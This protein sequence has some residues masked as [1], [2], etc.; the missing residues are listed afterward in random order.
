ML[1]TMTEK[2][3]LN[4][5]IIDQSECQNCGSK[6]IITDKTRGEMICSQCGLV[7]EDK[8]VDFSIEW[9]AYNQTEFE[10]RAR[11]ETTSYTLNKDLST[12]I[13][14]EN[15]D[16]SGQSISV[17]KQVQFNRLRRWQIRYK[18]QDS[19]DRN[20]NI[21]NIE[22]NRLCSQLQVPKNVKETAGQLY[23]RSFTTGALRGFPINSMIA[24]SVYAAARVRRI[25]RTLEEVSDETSI[26]KKRLAQCYR[27]LVNRMNYKIPPTRPTD[28]ILRIGTE[29][30]MSSLTQQLAVNII[31]D[32]VDN[33]LTNGKDPSGLAA[34]AL[35]LAGIS[36]GE[37]RTQQS[38]AKVARVTE[39][40][41][42]HR[43]KDL[44]TLL[45]VNA[46]KDETK[47]TTNSVS[48]SQL[49]R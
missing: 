33:K 39:V 19:K 46:T 22:L 25:P 7:I 23:K 17:E 32:A 10:K 24:A 34:S 37:K 44:I 8:M 28:L 5:E 29:I 4:D 2:K 18:S 11:T 36:R 26:T 16:A 31:N 14:L 35:Y 21:A 15:K 1:K 48:H 27:L 9:R 20:L 49:K 41:I 47:K 30:A 42:R 43:C 38:L 3:I 6:E 12:Y 13:G 40:T 45:G